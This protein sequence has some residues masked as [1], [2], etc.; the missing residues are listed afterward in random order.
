[1]GLRGRDKVDSGAENAIEVRR[2]I[3]GRTSS[4]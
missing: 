3:D 2:G 4:A 1:M